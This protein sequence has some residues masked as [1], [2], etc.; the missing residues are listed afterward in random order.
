MIFKKLFLFFIAILPAVIAGAQVVFIPLQS[1]PTIENYLKNNPLSK[2]SIMVYDTISLPFFDDFSKN[3]VYPDASLWLDNDV[4]INQSYGDNPPSLGV[5]SFDAIDD[6]GKL[7]TNASSNSFISD[8]LTSKPINLYDYIIKNPISISTALLFYYETATGIYRP[9][10]SLYY[11]IIGI[12]Y[13]CVLVPNTYNVDMRIWYKDGILKE[14]SDSLY[15]YNTTTML[16][17]HIDKYLTLKYSPADSLYLSFYYQPQGLAGNPPETSDSL[18]LE[19]R[20][21]DGTWKH[22]WSVNGNANKDFKQIL[23]PFRDTLFLY[24]GFQFRFKNY[25]SISSPIYGSFA[26][27]ADVWNLDYLNL[28]LNRSQNDTISNDVAFV[29][30][31]YSFLDDYSSVPWTHYKATPGFQEDTLRFYYRNLSDTLKTVARHYKIVNKTT[32]TTILNLPLGSELDPAFSDFYFKQ[33]DTSKY[34]PSTTGEIANFEIKISLSSSSIEINKPYVWNDTLVYYQKFANYYAYDDGTPEMGIG[35]AGN[36]TQNGKFAFEFYTLIP[37]TLRGIYMFFNRTLNN[38]NQK[39][40]YLT[41]WS[42]VNGKPGTLIYKQKESIRP[43]FQGLNEFH[44]YSLDTSIIITNKFFIGW[45]Q[46]D[47]ELLDIGY[48]LNLDASSKVFY[49]TDGYWLNFPSNGTPMMRPVFSQQPFDNIDEHFSK[50]DIKIYPNPASEIINIEAPNDFHFQLFNI[51]GSCILEKCNDKNYM[52]V[53]D[54]SPG[55]Y[56]IKGSNGT[57]VFTRKIIINR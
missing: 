53:S 34:F 47:D 40:F 42:S 8:Y 29:E 22:I 49:N 50:L 36:G 7:H 21:P 51:T 30:N 39:Y 17:E 15:T 32:G 26:G 28:N 24:K 23:I 19:F 5:A 56:F 45:I 14:V 37:D 2:R 3:I 25:A 20:I 9:A 31:S 46:T 33:P 43:E 13:N 44:F 41:V 35:L 55:L 16:Y 27:N 54:I 57:S 4:F 1:N 11:K 38:T 52:D 18:V 10:D 6:E 12:P 48:D